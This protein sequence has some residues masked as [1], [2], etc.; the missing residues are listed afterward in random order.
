MLLGG[1]ASI[2]PGQ[3]RGVGD[4]AAV[5]ALPPLPPGPEFESANSYELFATAD[6]LERDGKVE[7]AVATLEHLTALADPWAIEAH[8]ALGRLYGRL[9]DGERALRR[10]DLVLRMAPDEVEAQTLRGDLLLAMNRPDEALA[11]YRAA[12][13]GGAQDPDVRLRVVDL[14]VAAGEH[15]AALAQ[16]DTLALSYGASW[17]VV[18]RKSDLLAQLRGAEAALA[19]LRGLGGTPDG[20]RLLLE[21]QN[22]EALGR[23]DE[24]IA[25]YREALRLGPERLVAHERLGELLHASGDAEGAVAELEAAS[26]LAPRRPRLRYRLALALA[27]S[28]RRDEAHVILQQLV[29]AKPRDARFRAML[30]AL[31]SDM[32][33]Y[34]EARMNFREVVLQEPW[35][36]EAWTGLA[37]LEGIDSAAGRAVLERAVVLNPDAPLLLF[38]L[39]AAIRGEGELE[40]AEALVERGIVRGLATEDA[41]F[42]LGAIRE[43]RNDVEGAQAAFREVLKRNPDNAS[44]LNYIGYMY[45]DRTLRLQE[46]LEMIQRACILEPENG[47]FVDSLGWVYFRLGEMERAE[48]ELRR[49]LTLAD[50]DPVIFEHLGDV[51]AAR[52]RQGEAADAYRRSLDMDPTNAAVR[53]RLRELQ[54]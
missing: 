24:A 13:A 1:C 53:A 47:Y 28:G 22:L 42:E 15:R 9:G 21:A 41:F 45:A 23:S 46:S 31:A 26:A 3:R 48:A 44:A 34:D 17:E 29:D 20:D 37:M 54:P 33:L 6:L 50:D 52:G 16:V 4:D 39:G 25:A 27:D 18:Q 7:E 14:L 19:Y 43:Q 10:V 49:A 32:E 51:L 2:A 40:R 12:L 11:A 38:L 30:A 35:S 8:L 36:V 5:E